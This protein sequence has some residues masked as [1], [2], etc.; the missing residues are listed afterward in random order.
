MRFIISK[1]DMDLFSK[2]LINSKGRIFGNASFCQCAIFGSVIHL[3][4]LIV[5]TGFQIQNRAQS[6]KESKFRSKSVVAKNG[7]K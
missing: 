2:Y 5:M 3:L 4:L 7:L 1:I 6:E